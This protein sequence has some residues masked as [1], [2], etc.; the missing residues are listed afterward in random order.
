VTTE[1]RRHANLLRRAGDSWYSMIE[2]SSLPVEM[3]S[4][5]PVTG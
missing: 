2:M 4:G 1:T 3:R 5:V